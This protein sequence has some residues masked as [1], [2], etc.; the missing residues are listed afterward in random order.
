MRILCLHGQGSSAVIFESQLS[1]LIAALPSHYSFDFVDAPLSCGPG[2]DIGGVYPGPYY[3]FFD[4]YTPE[5]M[6]DAIDYVR[7]VID[8][9]GPYEAIIAFSQVRRLTSIIST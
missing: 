6:V 1:R 8:E 7:E 3:C 9:D 4:S 2:L 5:R